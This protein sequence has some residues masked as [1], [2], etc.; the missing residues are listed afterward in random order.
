MSLSR[1]AGCQC[2]QAA[3]V[4]VAPASPRPGRRVAG[5]S[6]GQGEPASEPV[7]RPYAATAGP[8]QPGLSL[9][10]PFGP[11]PGGPR[12]DSLRSTNPGQVPGS[13]SGS[14]WLPEN[15]MTRIS[16]SESLFELT[17]APTPRP[18]E[19]CKMSGELG[20]DGEVESSANRGMSSILKRLEKVF[21][22]LWMIKD[23]NFNLI[24]QT[25]E[26]S[27]HYEALQQYKSLYFRYS[28]RKRKEAVSFR[29]FL[30]GEYSFD[31][32]LDRKRCKS[33]TLVR[34]RYFCMDKERLDLNCLCYLSRVF[35]IRIQ[36]VCH[37]C[38][39]YHRCCRANLYHFRCFHVLLS[40]TEPHW[41]KCPS[42]GLSEVLFYF[43]SSLGRK[44]ISDRIDFRQ[45]NSSVLMY[46]V[47]RS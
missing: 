12:K 42:K 21:Y 33:H 1:R 18:A 37:I 38:P 25:V 26:E 31:V 22:I 35:A 3:Q 29:I 32:K 43:G 17:W 2:R 5:G 39:F 28:T 15:A 44:Y 40:R 24:S 16:W 11:G 23:L 7:S 45:Q 9:R 4:Q 36:K 46:F 34:L 30:E 20:N 10:A 6:P 8:G 14:I 27:R 19:W 47:I 41:H 13:S